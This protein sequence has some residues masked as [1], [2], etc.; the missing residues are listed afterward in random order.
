MIRDKAESVREGSA[1]G[2][3]LRIAFVPRNIVRAIIAYVVL[4]FAVFELAVGQHHRKDW[5]ARRG[6]SR[7]A[8]I[9]RKR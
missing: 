9:G 8:A 6:D 2:V 7:R 1:D 5:P 3:S 4:T